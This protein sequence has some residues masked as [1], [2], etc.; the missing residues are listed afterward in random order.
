MKRSMIA[1]L[2]QW[3]CLPGSMFILPIGLRTMNRQINSLSLK[4]PSLTWK[5]S[6]D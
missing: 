6:F 2:Q 5:R 4:Y 1:L 3:F